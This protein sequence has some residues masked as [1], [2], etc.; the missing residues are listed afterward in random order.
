MMARGTNWK[1]KREEKNKLQFLSKQTLSGQKKQSI[2][3]SGL[4]LLNRIDGKHWGE[5][6]GAITG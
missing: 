2:H 5:V 1:R 6:V 4:L 3:V